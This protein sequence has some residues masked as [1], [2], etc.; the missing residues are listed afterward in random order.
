MTISQILRTASQRLP[1]RMAVT[2]GAMRFTFA[3]VEA[4]S[5]HLARVLSLKGIGPGDRVVWWGHNRAEVVALHFAI[6]HLGAVFTPINPKMAREEIAPLVSLVDPALVIGDE[7]HA[8][9][10]E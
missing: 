7:D 9:Q 5:D 3:E 2:H 4:Q 8:G 6:A 10:V 1:Q